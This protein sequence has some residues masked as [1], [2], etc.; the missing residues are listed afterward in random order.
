MSPADIDE[1]LLRIPK[2]P[3]TAIIPVP[4]VSK[5]DNVSER[6]VWRHYPLVQTGLR[7]KG[8]ALGFLRHRTASA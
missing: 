8:V 4:V 5:H 7:R 2:L 6:H 1:I 3:D